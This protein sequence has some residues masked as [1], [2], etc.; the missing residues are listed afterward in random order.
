MASKTKLFQV[1]MILPITK[2]K[3]SELFLR[4]LEAMCELGFQVSALAEGD[5]EAQ[6]I[7]FEIAQKYPANFQIVESLPKNREQIMKKVNILLFPDFPSD[8]VLKEVVKEGIIPVLPKGGKFQNF[9][10]QKES[11][12]A[13][14][15]SKN[16]FWEFL[17]AIIR[18]SENFKFSY[19]W[20]NLQKN[21][22]ET[23]V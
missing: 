8:K 14:T 16:N 18:A 17:A 6:S 11:G 12:N 19:D 1:G 22:K 21:I 9:D 3:N 20:Q 7:C 5:M 13:F 2:D 10:P 15:F 23:E 4:S